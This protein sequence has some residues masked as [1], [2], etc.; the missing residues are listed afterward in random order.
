V[1][2]AYRLRQQPDQSG[3]TT[4]TQ[5]A[6]DFRT[7]SVRYQLIV[8]DISRRLEQLCEFDDRQTSVRDISAA[9]KLSV[10]MTE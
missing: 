3:K 4:C 8:R 6:L 7:G 10:M 2:F 1:T 5:T 9:A